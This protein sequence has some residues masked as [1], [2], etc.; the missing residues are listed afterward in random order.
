MV[1][2]RYLDIICIELTRMLIFFFRCIRSLKKYSF[3]TCN[4][5]GSVQGPGNNRRNDRDMIVAL[6]LFI[7]LW[8]KQANFNLGLSSLIQRS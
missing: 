1:L 3:T 4:A 2:M 8:S 5:P 7:T 6:K